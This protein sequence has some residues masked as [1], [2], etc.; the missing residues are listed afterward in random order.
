[1]RIGIVSDLHCNVQGLQRAIELMGAVDELICCGDAIYQYR[2]SNET[3]ALLR[4]SDAHVIW[5]NHEETLLGPDGVR[6]RAAEWVDQDLVSWLNAQP[7]TIET[8]VNGHRLFVV[9][10][11]PWAPTEEYIFPTSRSLAKF[12]GFDAD[13]VLMGH[14]HVQ[15][16]H[17]ATGPTLINPGST[18]EA[19]D[20][21]NHRRLS[22]AILDSASREISFC[23]FPD[24]SR[25]LMMPDGVSHEPEWTHIDGTLDVCEK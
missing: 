9:H 2:F 17:R 11:S 8:R 3:V 18:G 23:N 19:R 7:L 21:A 25:P 15:M 6:A 14:T 4:D 16:A 10:G 13:Y 12:D 22:F 1:M 20:S 5:G 24:P